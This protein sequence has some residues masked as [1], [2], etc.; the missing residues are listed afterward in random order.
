MC[1]LLCAEWEKVQV[2]CILGVRKYYC[3]L[4]SVHV[5]MCVVCP[6]E[7][8]QPVGG[9]SACPSGWGRQSVD[10]RT[11]AGYAAGVG[12]LDHL[13]ALLCP[14]PPNVALT[15]SQLFC[16]PLN[17]V[18]MRSTYTSFLRYKQFYIKQ[19]FIITMCTSICNDCMKYIW[20]MDIV[21]CYSF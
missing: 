15:M 2:Y 21:A 7:W 14:P 3:I 9:R 12:A 8:A 16:Q 17:I 4:G 13:V 10:G 11:P 6:T 19:F 5:L 18:N 20:R 1:K